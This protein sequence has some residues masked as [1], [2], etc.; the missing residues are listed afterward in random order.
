MKI[1]VLDG[2][3]L[4]PG[5][6]P[7]D[8]IA[9]FGELTVYDRTPSELVVARAAD[10]DVLIVN[11][12]PVPAAAL[13]RLA[14][15]VRHIAVV[16]TG[17][18]IVDVQAARRLGISVSNVPE[19]GTA[20]VAQLVFALLLELCHRVGDHD[21]SVKAGD[22]SS[23]PDFC[24]W[25]QPLVELDGL[26]LGIVGFGR[27]GRRVGEIAHAFGMSVAAFDATPGPGPAY[28]PFEYVGLDDLFRKSDVVSLHCPLTPSS[29]RLVN[30]ARLELMKPGSLL[31]NTSRGKLIDQADLADA[32]R[33]GRIA[34]AA[35]DVVWDEPISPDNPLLQ[36]PN[37]L[38]TPHMA[39]ATLAARRR[40]MST[41][42]GNIEAFLAGRPI[43]IVN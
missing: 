42:A 37:C 29:L 10:A 7:W 14:G 39:W 36:A 20:S 6:N 17:Y 12:T 4:N 30:R 32:L 21:R 15:R 24:Y 34:G 18:D 38:I 23:C 22:W 26:R 11:K 27:I 5:D 43:N 19:Y 41:A 1:V 28:S 40:L 9:R 13:E 16:A 3:T 2:Y 25:N 35:L 31:V 33:R 8:P